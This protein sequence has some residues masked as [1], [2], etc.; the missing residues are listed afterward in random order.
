MVPRQHRRSRTRTLRLI[1]IIRNLG[2]RI[3]E[4]RLNGWLGEVDGLQ[5]SLNAATAKLSTLDRIR[6]R[7]PSSTVSLGVPV[8]RR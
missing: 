4:A 6:E 5:T 7:P 3:Q 8:V 1:E 2:E